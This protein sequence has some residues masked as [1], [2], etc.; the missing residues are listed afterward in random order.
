MMKDNGK[1]LVE[2]EDFSANE[3]KNK[4]LSASSKTGQEYKTVSTIA[5]GTLKFDDISHKK[6]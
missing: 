5:N 3:K 1:S 2:K 6:K 4:A